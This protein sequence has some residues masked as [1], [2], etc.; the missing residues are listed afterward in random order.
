MDCGT[1]RKPLCKLEDPNF[2][3]RNKGKEIKAISNLYSL[4]NYEEKVRTIWDRSSWSVKHR[5]TTLKKPMNRIAGLCYVLVMIRTSF[6]NVK[7]LPRLSN[8]HLDC[9]G[10]LIANPTRYISSSFVVDFLVSFCI[11]SHDQACYQRPILL[12][13]ALSSTKGRISTGAS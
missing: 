13:S 9:A 4:W 7:D 10:S 3:I 6:T 1:L 12:Q 5:I 11:N 2:Y 8:F